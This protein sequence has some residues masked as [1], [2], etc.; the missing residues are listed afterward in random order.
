MPPKGAFQ[1]CTDLAAD[2]ENGA[3]SSTVKRAE[4]KDQI[5]WQDWSD[6]DLSGQSFAGKTFFK[7]SLRRARLVGADFTGALICDSELSDADLTGARLD[8]ALIGGATK[9]DD[10]NFS[11]ASA[12]GIV[13]ED[14]IGP[15]RIDGADMRG[16][17]TFCNEMPACLEKSVSFASIVGADLR[18]AA[19]GSFCCDTPGLGT[20]RLDGVATPLGYGS[21]DRSVFDLAQFGAGVGAHGRATFVP[22][23]ARSN[24]RSVTFTGHELQQLPALIALMSKQGRPGFDCTRARTVAE[25][26]VCSSPELAALDNGLNW[27]WRRSVVR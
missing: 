3:R 18:G 16:A 4:A 17:S 27:L 14:A 26:T 19:I 25:R 11:N 9:L 5:A 1:A 12:R 22:G 23:T 7:V 6:R 24:R 15:I 21:G 10:A 2:E 20:A 13:I 8:R